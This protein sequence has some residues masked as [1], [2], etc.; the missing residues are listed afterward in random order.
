[1]APPLRGRNVSFET[2]REVRTFDT[3][4]PRWLMPN[5]NQY[6]L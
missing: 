5:I 4:T 2:P 6:A 3:L 1:M